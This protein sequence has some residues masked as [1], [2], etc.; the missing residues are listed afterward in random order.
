MVSE[1]FFSNL[2]NS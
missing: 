1:E 2:K